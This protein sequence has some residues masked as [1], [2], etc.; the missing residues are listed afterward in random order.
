M[1]TM[2]H[3]AAFCPRPGANKFVA[4][5]PNVTVYYGLSGLIS[6][7]KLRLF[8]FL[9]LAAHPGLG[10]SIRQ[11]LTP[12]AS[13]CSPPAQTLTACRQTLLIG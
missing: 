9:S 7:S 10:V 3:R 6:V 13:T 2:S 11:K 1:T 8:G 12:A 5:A 4:A